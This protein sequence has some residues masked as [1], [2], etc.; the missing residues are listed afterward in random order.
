M[1]VLSAEERRAFSEISYAIGDGRPHTL[2]DIRGVAVPKQKIP[3]YMSLFVRLN[4]FRTDGK[5]YTIA[6]T[7]KSLFIHK[8]DSDCRNAGPRISAY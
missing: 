3:E 8:R 1:S 4:L 6:G 5:F 7:G 2:E